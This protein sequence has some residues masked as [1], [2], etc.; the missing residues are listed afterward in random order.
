MT[1]GKALRGITKW[2]SPFNI[3]FIL[4]IPLLALRVALLIFHHLPGHD[5][6]SH[7]L[8]LQ[9]L[10]FNET[11]LGGNL[12]NWF[13]FMTHGTTNG[14]LFLYSQNL[15]L[16]IIYPFAKLLKD[17]NYLYIFQAT[18]LFDELILLLGCLLLARYHFKSLATAIFVSTSIA[19]T[20]ISSYQVHLD[21]HI[22]YLIPLIIYCL[23]RALKQ[24]SARY[25][26]LAGI[27]GIITF[28]GNAAYVVPFI[29]FSI[30]VFGAVFCCLTPFH[31]TLLAL[32]I[33][34]QRFSWK[35]GVILL[36]LIYFVANIGLYLQYATTEILSVTTGRDEHG[37]VPIETFL[38]YGSI[39]GIN[40]SELLIWNPSNYNLTFYMGLL[41]IPFAIIAFIRVRSRT[42][43]VFGITAWVLFLFGLGTFVSLFYYYFVPAGKLFR[44]IIY[45]VQVVKIF[46]VFY[47]G[48]G[49]EWYWTSLNQK[50]YVPWK[51]KTWQDKLA[52]LVP[53][54]WT[55]LVFI[56][57]LYMGHFLISFSNSAN[58]V[59]W[60][61]MVKELA[62][63]ILVTGGLLILLFFIIRRPQ[64]AIIFAYIL[65]IGHFCDVLSLKFQKEYVQTPQVSE[66]VANLFEVYPYQFP[67]Q[68][69]QDYYTNNRFRLLAPTFLED[70]LVENKPG[71]LGGQYGSLYW[72]LDAFCFF[73]AAA[74]PF[75]VNSWLKGIEAFHSV[76]LPQ[77]QRV[78]Q[79]PGFPI[80][81]TQ[82]YKKLSGFGF[83][84]LQLFS[85]IHVL[86]TDQDVTNTLANSKFLAT[87]S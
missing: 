53:T 75:R 78:Y 22:S 52:L 62:L 15:L 79:R 57:L 48:F 83:P 30:C 55:V 28:L 51:N 64:Q 65:L 25:F 20:T 26:F 49:F 18:L 31:K 7:I 43:Y 11:A 33:L 35:H 21:F 71:P 63:Q 8:L 45:T 58:R 50:P 42:S 9:Y 72:T 24:A 69:S 32:Q 37:M 56:I 19:Y 44:H 5:T 29:W 41:V 54:I 47:A 34:W 80:I 66:A 82:A 70:K 3:L 60:L 36:V 23:E 85:K 39:G 40:Y 14:L 73:D 86:P 1:P 16:P 38:T 59:L 84:K 67:I 6:F 27:L 12:P 10:F 77:S 61:E 87:Y 17:I 81:E 74:S 46:F 13:P 76:W 4:L 68:R 2:Y